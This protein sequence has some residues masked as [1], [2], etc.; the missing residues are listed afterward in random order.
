MSTQHTPTAVTLSHDTNSKPVLRFEQRYEHSVARVWQALT[1]E[2]ELAVWYPTAVRIE[3]VSGGTIT[4]TFPGGEPF[5][6]R[7]LEATRPELLT[8]T[9]LDDVLRWELRAVGDGCRLVLRNTVADPPHTP[10]TAA[11][12]HIALNQLATLLD[13][14]AAAVRRTEMP[15]PDDLVQHYRQALNLASSSP[16]DAHNGVIGA[17]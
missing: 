7:V 8:F 1:S 15:P 3:P 16:E 12:F 17:E 14:G 9:T 5:T 2:H 10:Y 13:E 11:G 4:F 6:G